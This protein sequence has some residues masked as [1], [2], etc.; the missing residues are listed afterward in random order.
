MLSISGC[1]SEKIWMLIRHGTRYPGKKWMSSLV[2]QIP[3]LKKDILLARKAKSLKDDVYDRLSSWTLGF[4]EADIMNLA[5][6]GESELID[7]AERY[8]TRFPHLFPEVY[9]NDTYKVKK[10]R[11]IIVSVELNWI[12]IYN[13]FYL[14]K[15]QF[16]Y[17]NTQ[18]T[19]ESAKHFA[20]G[21]FG[22]EGSKRVYFPPPE[23]KDPI[24]RV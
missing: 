17:T 14:F 16:K 11:V 3:H 8:Q 13:N 5:A 2:T 21:L 9:S 15:L 24:L 10:K 6:E 7:I 12:M 23:D 20:I 4:T 22:L 1:K 18:R 19:R